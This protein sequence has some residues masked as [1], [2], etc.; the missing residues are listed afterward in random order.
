MTV[1]EIEEILNSY[2]KANSFYEKKL[3]QLFKI[4]HEMQGLKGTNYES[5][6][7]QGGEKD[8]ALAK[9]L[10]KALELESAVSLALIRKTTAYDHC[11]KLIF[12]LNNT[13]NDCDILSDIYLLGKS[14]H[15]VAKK[16]C[17]DKQVLWNKVSRAKRALCKL[18]TIKGI[19][20]DNF[21]D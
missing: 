9:L 8:T 6:R 20:K 15:D 17:Y 10:D 12:V 14:Y 19:T 16:Y 18:T 4:R 3:L 1:N 21:E 5:I 11:L 2:R 13:Y 7:V